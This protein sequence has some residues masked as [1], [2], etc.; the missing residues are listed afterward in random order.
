[1]GGVD[2]VSLRFHDAAHERDKEFVST[3]TAAKTGNPLESARVCCW[4]RCV[5]FDPTPPPAVST[6]MKV[7]ET[8]LW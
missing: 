5:A 7:D 6:H 4:T 1:M 2:D 8:S 3:S